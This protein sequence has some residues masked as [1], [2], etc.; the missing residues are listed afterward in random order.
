MVLCSGAIV[1][2]VATTLYVSSPAL[3]QGVGRYAPVTRET[4]TTYISIS[5]TGT[6]VS[7]WRNGTNTN[8]NRSTPQPVGLTFYYLGQPC[9]TFSISTNGHMDL[10]SSTATGSGSGA[11]GYENTQFSLSGGTLLALAPLYDDLVCQGNPGTQASLDATLKYQVD[12]SPGSRVLTV[13]WTGLEVS[14]NSGPDLNMQVKLYEATGVIEYVYGTMTPGT[15]TYSYT[16]GINGPNMISPPW[17]TQLLTQQTA[18]STTFS[19]PASNGLTTVPTSNSRLTFTPVQNVTPAA[20]I[21]MAFSSVTQTEMTVGWTDNSTSETY[22]VVR[23][24]T[25]NVTFTQVGAVPSTTVAGTGAAYSLAQT[26][27][28]VGTTYY[29]CITANNEGSAPSDCLSGSQATDPPADITSLQSG[30][31]SFAS[32]WVG[33]VVPS[34][35]DDV[36]IADGDTVTIDSWASCNSLTVGQGVS[37]VLQWGTA[38]ARGMAAGG[39]VTI[40]AGGTFRTGDAGAVT[41]HVLSVAGNLTNDGTLDFSTFGNACRAGITFTGPSNATF[42]GTG[43]T[44]DISTIAINKGT[45]PSSILELNPS[46][47]T[48]RGLTTD[49]AASAFLTLT[50]GTFKISGTFA[51]TH[52]VFTSAAYTVAATTGIWLNNPNFTVAGQN[53]SPTMNG[54]WRVSQGMYNIGTSDGN[55]MNLGTNS[56]TD[57]EGGTVTATGRIQA[58][59]PT[60]VIN[61]YQSDGTVTVCTVGNPS[62]TYASFDMG[63]STGSNVAI[64]GGVI[65]LQLPCT[66]PVQCDYRNGSLLIPSGGTLQVGNASTGA[67][68]TYH[69]QGVMSDL[70]ITSDF[71]HVVNLRGTSYA[72]NVTNNTGNT[73]DLNGS[74]LHVL[75]PTF[76]N[77]GTLIGNTFGSSLYFW[78]SVTAWRIPVLDTRDIAQ[79][80]T[81]RLAGALGRADGGGTLSRSNQQ[82][83]SGTGTVV[84]YLYT[85]SID[86]PL[87]VSITSDNQVVTARVNLF[88]GTVTNSNKIT[89]GYAGT[90]MGAT[91]IGSAGL[92]SAGGSYDQAPTFDYGPGRYDVLYAQEGVGRTTGLEVPPARALRNLQISNT[93]GVTIAGG[94]LSVTSNLTLTAGTLNTT[95]ADLLTLSAAATPPAGSAASYVNGPMAI[96]WSVTSAT[97]KTY[98]IGKGSA[99]R[100]LTMKS[101]DTGGVSRTFT[102]EA[103]NSASGGT[104]VPPLTTL[105]PARYWT[106]SNSANLNASARV[107]I[108]Y[109]ADD[110]VASLSS[111]HIGQSDAIA[112]SYT[113]IGGTATASTVES[114]VDLTPGSDYF[115]LAQVAGPVTWDGGAGTNNWSDAGNWDPDGVPT[116]PSNVSL[117]AGSA[118]INVNGMYAVSDLEIGSNIALNLATNTLTVNGVLTQWEGTIDLG[119]GTL[120]LVGSYVQIGGTLAPSEGTVLYSGT[121]VQTVLPATYYNLTL[122]NGGAGVPKTLTAAGI[123]TVTNDLTVESTAQLTISEAISTTVDVAG[124][125]N[126]AGIGGGTNIAWL[127]LDLTGTDRTIN[128]VSF[129]RTEAFVR[130]LPAAGRSPDFDVAV[131]VA[132]GASYA[133][134]DNISMAAGRTLTVTGRLNCGTYSIGGGGGISV[135]GTTGV[136]GTATTSASGLGATVLTTGS[137]TYVDGSIIEYNALGDQ[138][139]HSA[140]HP[141]ASMLYTAGSGTK[142]LDADLTISGDSG[143]TI[144]KAALWVGAGTTFGDGGH[145]LSFTSSGHDNV[146]VIGAFSSTGSGSIS[147]E[148]GPDGSVV[149]AVDGTA[150][151]DLTINFSSSSSW[152]YLGAPDASTVDISFRNILFGGTA[153]S[154]TAGGT[155]KL[156]RTGTTDL[157]VTGDVTLAPAVTSNTGGGFGGYASTGTHRV[158]VLGDVTSTSTATTQPIMLHTTGENFFTFGGTA[159]QHLL[160]PQSTTTLTNATGGVTTIV[161]NAAGV[162]LGGETARTYTIGGALNLTSGNFTTG[163][164]TLAIG[165]N[166][167]LSR[168]S[169]H[170]VGNLRKRVD[171]GSPVVNFQV[172]TGSD[173]APVSVAFAGVTNASGTLT[174]TTAAGD[175]AQ[176]ATSG[177]DPARTANRTWTLTNGGVVF[178]SCG[179]TLNFVPGDLDGGADPNSFYVRRYASSAWTAPATGARTGTSTQATGLSGFGDF[180]VGQSPSYTITATAGTGGSISPD[181]AVVVEYGADQEFTITADAG[182]DIADVVVD[183]VSHGAIGSY[184]FEDVDGDHTITAVFIDIAPPEAQLTAPN[185]GEVWSIGMTHPITWSATDN[186]GV[187]AVDLEYSTDGGATYPFAIAAGLADSGLYDW[188]IPDTQTTD[189]KVRLTAHDAAGNSVQDESDAAFAIQVVLSV[190]GLFHAAAV[191]DQGIVLRWQLPSFSGGAGLRIYRALSV[192]GPYGC[193]TRTPLMDA[194]AGTYVDRTAWPGGTFWYELR[195][196]LESGEEVPAIDARPS[197]TV[198]GALM[199]GIRYMTPNPTRGGASIGYTMPVGAQSARLSVYDAAGRLVRRLHST[200]DARGGFVTVEWDG[201]GDCGERPVSGVYFVRL[202]VDGAVAVQKL[203]VLR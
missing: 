63:T 37:G 43:A 47:F 196:V 194:E 88:T 186:A 170:I 82:T 56:V 97:T 158:T 96:E 49:S 67:A 80:D 86:N 195:A 118:T 167:S 145:R 179:V 106:I 102:A 20:P 178:V 177:L 134:G 143:P 161:D 162:S 35:Y 90:S 146:N 184:T 48:V 173:Y 191:P 155:M 123:Y 18:N 13:Q 104:P 132:S 108:G 202:E 71:S 171:P 172:G 1:A 203:T 27:L 175:H 121:V 95:A 45:S 8:D 32:T 61:Y 117:T 25:D 73:L 153:G 5:G 198:P 107:S 89:I 163:V 159:E 187:T 113:S 42:D 189:A 99:F 31:W 124:N 34:Q 197:V 139:V 41:T 101:V 69:V 83:F 190:E 201:R 11:Y 39:S 181:G 3:A 109:G 33:G 50:N 154:G 115:T 85:L 74:T 2:L 6:S 24:S 28:T 174:A 133:L 81:A 176:I 44:T 79:A 200:A 12:G 156:G 10:S 77:N 119:T 16:L 59:P 72:L 183:S 193:I 66:G 169:G 141:A 126:Y 64:S 94:G 84:E 164:N 110:G 57:I 166:G 14:G 142:T 53:G 62:G 136:L 92:T 152:L 98:A 103:F 70:V 199:F 17:P 23:R 129:A 55:S 36:T 60:T 9:T 182:Y 78:G 29:F 76:T 165:M 180:A 120:E 127:R 22:F 138:T 21:D 168:T 58:T 192:D 7:G 112:G 131:T 26:G 125:L 93:N 38:S 116:G 140:S 91:Q 68:E 4:G 122:R 30:N 100:P 185:G 114:T 75:G 149:Q 150:F 46:A 144:T 65:V 54:L 130:A 157:T 128:G 15:A 148:S 19:Y 147:Y 135:D 137:N 40:T 160:M 51:G 188:V 52:R 105:D 87:G 151:G 111:A